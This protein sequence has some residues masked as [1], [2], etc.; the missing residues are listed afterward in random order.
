MA[1]KMT[2]KKLE[3]LRETL[4]RH[5]HL[6]HVEARPEIS[7]R[8]FDLLLAELMELESQHPEWS[9]PNSPS[10]RVGGAPVEGFVTVPHSR[11][12][13][14]LGNTYSQDELREHDARLKRFLEKASPTAPPPLTYV[15]ELKIDGV[16]VALR[17]ENGAFVRGL[18]RGDGTKGEDISE[19]LRTVRGVPLRLGKGA[20]AQLEVRGEV[21]IRRSEFIEWNRRREKDG[22]PRLMNPRNSAAGSLKILDS[23]EVARR[24]LRVWIYAIVDPNEHGLAT[25]TDVMKKLTKLGFPVEPNAATE[26]DIEAAIAH[27]NHWEQARHE[28]DYETDGMVLK[29]D[30]HGLQETLG[31]TSKAPRWGIAYKFETSQAV[32]Q[33][34]DI[35]VQ[36]GRTGN[37]TPVANLEPVEILGTIVQRATLHNRDEIA[38]LDVRVG[39]WVEIEKGGEIIPKVVKVLADRR[40]A[41]VKPYVFPTECPS[42]QTQLQSSEEE[43]AVR[44]VNPLCPAQLRGRLEHFVGRGALDIEGIGETLVQQLVEAKLVHDLA[45]LYALT[46]P[47]LAGLERMGEKSATKVVEG[48]ARTRTPELSRFLFGLGVRHVGATAARMLAA[49]FGKLEALLAATEEELGAIHGIGEEIAQSVVETFART[50]T[51]ELLA[52]FLELGVEPE[53]TEPTAPTPGAWDGRVFVITGTLSEWT[54]DEAAAEIRERGG[55]VTSSVSKKTDFLIAGEKAGSKRTKAEKLEVRIIEEEEFHRALQDPASLT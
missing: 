38:R 1:A 31:F 10:G 28:L 44:C 18:T 30:D 19:N 43:V 21:Y 46:I 5:N 34:L 13:L 12:M 25:Q 15:A 14:S 36:I 49:H 16:G 3:K 55:N 2:R 4:H 23:R 9:D 48:L 47:Q 29:V 37:A 45:D 11:P 50:E 41:K 53:E 17:Y 6:Y 24:P 22:L 39:D 40:G 51:R 52:K 26:P 27:C 8:D 32:T 54:R 20:P 33:V 7:D 35:S 42:C